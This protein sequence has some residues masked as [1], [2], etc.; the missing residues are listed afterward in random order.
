MGSG[1]YTAELYRRGDKV[2]ARGEDPEVVA[3]GRTVKEAVAAFE[4]KLKLV[5]AQIAGDNAMRMVQSEPPC[6]EQ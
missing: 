2:I 4:E 5:L 1:A 6:H 3:N